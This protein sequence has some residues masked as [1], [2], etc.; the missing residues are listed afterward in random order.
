VLEP[1]LLKRVRLNKSLGLQIHYTGGKHQ[2]VSDHPDTGD[3]VQIF[4]CGNF[5]SGASASRYVFA[6]VPPHQIFNSMAAS[7]SKIE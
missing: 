3:L 7:F 1:S 6:S 2:Y 5:I 4:Q